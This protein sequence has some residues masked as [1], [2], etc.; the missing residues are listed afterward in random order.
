VI[1]YVFLLVFAPVALAAQ[2]GYLPQR[3]YD[4]DHK[5]FVDF[6]S[7]LADLMKAD[8]VFVGEQHDDPNTHRLELAILEGLGRRRGGVI[9][10]LEMFERD[11]QEP[12]EHYLMGHSTEEEFLKVSRPWPRYAT[13]YKPLVEFAIS[14]D[15]HVV[16][17]NVPRPIASD[18]SKSGFGALDSR[19]EAE[20]KWF[21]RERQCPTDD[22]Y[23]KRFGQ[24]MNEH[25]GAPAASEAAKRQMT[26]RFYFSQ[27]L[28]D[29]TMAE[30]IAQA[31]AAASAGGQRPLVVHFNGAFHSDFGQGTAARAKRRLPGKRI[32]VLS[33]L[34]V[35]ELDGL[36]PDGD[37]R[38]RG[39]YLVYTTSGS[40]LRFP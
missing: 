24:A 20:R 12:L 29:E 14:R 37:A 10:S 9:V 13:D 7:M 30:S 40:V 2:S 26:E 11:V 31:H 35:K 3:V 1:R 38:K 16:A 32:V 22:D 17:A 33:V 21:A 18:V 28:K 34:P 15:W 19:P 39:D 25:P 27:C 36:S 8:V 5:R 6:E 4:T 23:F